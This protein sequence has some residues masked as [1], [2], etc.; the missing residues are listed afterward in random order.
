[1][2]IT[3]RHVF[4]EDGKLYPQIFLD[5][6]LYELLKYQNMTE[7]IFQKELMLTKQINQKNAC[8]VIIGIFYIGTLVMDHIFV[9]DVII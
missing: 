2:T 1:M 7:S 9:M 5:D 8:F 3:I 6:T 4:E